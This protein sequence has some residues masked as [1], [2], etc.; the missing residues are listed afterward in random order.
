[1]TYFYKDSP[2]SKQEHFFSNTDKLFAFVSH[3]HMFFLGIKICLYLETIQELTQFLIQEG[4]MYM[5][6]VTIKKI[7]LTNSNIPNCTD[8]SI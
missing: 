7:A 2:L 6:L 8:Y 4:T 1:M 5:Y 3:H